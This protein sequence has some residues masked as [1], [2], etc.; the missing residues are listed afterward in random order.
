MAPE[1]TLAAFEKAIE[2]GADGI[3]FD[4]HLT[5]D[6]HVVVHHDYC[7]NKEWARKDGE[8]L[9][10]TG[11]A[12]R[13]L[14]LVQVQSYDMG[15]LAPG[16]VYH[17]KYPEYLAAD[18]ARIPTLRQ[19][20]GLVKGRA[21]TGFQLW[22]EL[23][24]APLS[25]EPTSD[26]I[27]LAQAA[28]ALLQ[29]AGM[30]EQTTVISFYWP[31]LYHA[32]RRVPDLKTGYL[33]IQQ[34]NEDNIQADQPGLSAW[35]AP[36]DAGD[37]NGSVPEMIKAAGGSAWSAY[38]RDLTPDILAK[39]KDIGLSVGIWTIRQE[40]EIAVAKALRVEVITTDRPD[41]FAA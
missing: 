11:P 33:S 1:N 12:I 41:W 25:Q 29:D 5:S 22:L 15:R 21:P 30:V 24:L 2:V 20:L 6:G 23:K 13:D 18:G 16:S 34:S 36:I 9:A 35:T 27:A 37:H 31:A 3:E 26:A 28:L 14:T 38:W 32:Q 10:E 17:A 40:A 7:I 39:A 19:V 4:V 8:W